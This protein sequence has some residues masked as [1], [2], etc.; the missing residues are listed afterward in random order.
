ME[1]LWFKE[2]F[3]F[4][5]RQE[6]VYHLLFPL[7]SLWF[8]LLSFPFSTDWDLEIRRLYLDETFTSSD[9]LRY[10]CKASASSGPSIHWRVYHADQAQWE[11]LGPSSGPG[12]DI[13]P[14]SLSS[15]VVESVLVIHRSRGPSSGDDVISCM[16]TDGM[17]TTSLYG[18]NGKNSHR[19][20]F[21]KTNLTFLP[22]RLYDADMT[23]LIGA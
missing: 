17:D 23:Y 10:V 16:A 12:V 4:A 21:D 13:T 2:S 5:Q 8:F 3:Y 20:N 19:R 9:S 18:R 1:T 6:S 7:W 14:T 15:C 11:D 22:D